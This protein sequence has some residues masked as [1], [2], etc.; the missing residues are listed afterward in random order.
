VL[1]TAVACAIATTAVAAPAAQ[2][3]PP[4]WDPLGPVLGLLQGKNGLGE[5]LQGALCAPV[6]GVDSLVRATGK[7]P[8][9]DL[10][11]PVTG[12]LTSLVCNA[13]VIDYQFVTKLREPDGSI[14]ERVHRTALGVPTTLNV[15]HDAEPDLVGTI[16]LTGP[17]TVGLVVE[18]AQNE[19]SP[20]PVQVEAVLG[21]S[22]GTVLGGRRIAIGYDARD[23]R[24]PRKFTISTPVDTITKSNGSVRANIQQNDPGARIAVVADIFDGSPTARLNETAI[25]LDYRKSPHNASFTASLGHAT[26]L[27][28]TTDNPGGLLTASVDSPDLKADVALRA[29]PAK[30][31]LAV[32]ADG[33]QVTYNGNGTS[34]ERLTADI[35]SAQDLIGGARKLRVDLLGMPVAGAVKMRAPEG[36]NQQLG[37]TSDGVIDQIDVRASDAT[38]G[39]PQVPGADTDGGAFLDTTGGKFRL[40][41]RIFKLK[42]I[43]VDPSPMSLEVQTDQAQTFRIDA[44]IDGSG[45]GAPPIA[46]KATIQDLPTALKLGLVEDGANSKLQYA[47][48]AP[49][50]L[51]DAEA[52]GISVVDGADKLHVKLQGI[53]GNGDIGLRSDE[54]GTVGLVANGVNVDR[55]EVEAAEAGGEFPQVP[56]GAAGAF[57]DA[58]GGKFRLAARIYQ[59]RAITI[60]PSPMALTLDTGTEGPFRIDAT[61]PGSDAAAP[62]IV[63]KATI[64]ELPT[65]LKIG[66]A[67][68]S[69]G[70]KLLYEANAPID[71]IDVQAT[72]V[73]LLDGADKLHVK[74]QQIDGNGSI[75]IRTPAE[76]QEGS[77]LGLVAD[78]VNVERIELEAADAT[79]EFP[80]VPGGPDD[81]GAFLDSTN[82]KFRLAA[83][84][85][86]LRAIEVGTSP[87]SLRATTGV[88][89]PFRVDVTLPPTEEDPGSGDPGSGDPGSG[90]P[91]SGDPG[92]GDPGSGDPGGTP[93]QCTPEQ[94]GGGEPGGGEPGGGEPGGGEP[95]GGE[96]G[97]GEPGG[98]PQPIHV[99]AEVLDLPTTFELGLTAPAEG[100]DEDTK[101]SYEASSRVGDI[102]IKATGVP[103][104]EGSDDIEAAI[105]DVPTGFTLALPKQDCTPGTPL[106][107]LTTADDQA[108]G[109]L[110]LAAGRPLPA[111]GLQPNGDP[112]PAVD[113]LFG[114]S[115][116]GGMGVAV[117]LTALKGLSITLDPIAIHLDQDATKSKPIVLDA[118]MAQ[119]GSTTPSTITGRI[120]KTSAS[121]TIGTELAEGQPTKL[122]FENAANLAQIKLKALNLGDIPEL[123]LTLDNIPPKLDVCVDSGP[124]CRRPNPNV[125]SGGTGGGDNRPFA[126]QTSMNFEDSGTQASGLTTL[127][128]KL[129]M[130]GQ[131]V[132]VTNLR[133]RNLGMDLGQGP[134]FSFLGNTIPRMYMF[135]DSRNQQFVMNEIK[136]PPT[137]ESFKIGSDGNPAVASNRIVWL[138]GTKSLGLQLDTAAG[139]SL[140]CKGTA[141]LNM[142]V[143]G[144]NI[145][146]LNFLGTQMLPV[147]SAG[148]P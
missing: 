24:A 6:S 70:Q 3:K 54:D 103:L 4:T 129:P 117:R 53:D 72:G 16:T 82:G 11:T 81:A 38:S 35:E 121:T 139:G 18:R 32:D 52:S 146:L 78:G 45:Q 119:E 47:A 102:R 148:K 1:T 98:G 85:F 17:N 42:S 28:A 122:K 96:P 101:L 13:G 76:G 105:H 77:K 126:A 124:R 49:I 73:P 10:L 14:T 46:A 123:D 71:Q 44:A 66:L 58:T 62:P 92:S 106:A 131:T 100:S 113:D 120:S 21:N 59:L 7:N 88:S 90:D 26:A 8:V 84:V 80:Q 67:E 142:K 27:S 95:G 60:N 132:S 29:L 57:V 55:I 147:C 116:S 110:R 31:D 48:S 125:L 136:Y 128:A 86:Q 141:A 93:T 87:V 97:G 115:T 51:I 94:P 133:F 50:S 74:L 99:E 134:T 5:V 91:G 12:G 137:V 40:A 109:E 138:K 25:R 61:L 79:S 75:A 19:K 114:Y 127:N 144:L 143:L 64:D 34:I 69:S 89:K 9:S 41:A 63:A 68:D 15:D 65:H 36:G 145:N 104:L 135:I 108:I 107:K 23:D 2:A 43:L 140:D 56:G 30:L 112:D 39:Y 20:L 130:A 83:R 118:A 33:G 22:K 111:T 37:L